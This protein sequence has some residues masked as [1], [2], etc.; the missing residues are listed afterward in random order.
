MG[1]Y[2]PN[3]LD[4]KL[5]EMDQILRTQEGF[6]NVFLPRSPPTQSLV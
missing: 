1:V 3:S 2:N 5:E 4:A 6:T